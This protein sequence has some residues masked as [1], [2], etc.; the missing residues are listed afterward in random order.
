ME[1]KPV[2]YAVG[3]G[4]LGRRREALEA[5]RREVDAVGGSKPS[6]GFPSEGGSGRGSDSRLEQ[7]RETMREHERML[8]ELGQGVGRLKTQSTLINDETSLHVRLLDDMEGEAASASAGLRTEARHAENIRAKTKTFN[9]YVIIGVLSV[10]LI[11]LI[12]AG[13]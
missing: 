11:I 5:L 6:G 8:E 13:I 12:C 2:D 9:L 1:M 7:Q 4:E 10:I 3:Q